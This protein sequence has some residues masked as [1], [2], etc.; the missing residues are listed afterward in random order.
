MNSGWRLSSSVLVMLAAGLLAVAPG[1]TR[2]AQLRDPLQP[3]G[4]WTERNFGDAPRPPMGWN[5]WNAFHT[6]IDEAKLLGS[7]RVIV[8]SGLRDLGY[9]YINIDDGWWL[10]RHQPDGRMVVRAG[11]FPSAFNRDPDRTSFRPLVDQLHAMHLKAGIYTDIGRN[12]CSQGYPQPDSLLPIGTIAEREVGLYGHVHQDLALYFDEWGFDYIKVDGCGLNAFAPD[13]PAVEAGQFRAFP[14]YVVPDSINQTRVA[15]IR[16]L[17]TEVRDELIRLRPAGNFVF[18]IC[19]WGTANV[20]AWGRD[21][22]NLWRTSDDIDGHWARMLYN[23]DSVATRE[24]YSGP[25]HWNDPDMLEVGHGDFDAHH[26]A[27]ARTHFALWAIE[28]APLIIGLDLRQAPQS[29]LDV[30][31]APEVI[32]VDQDPA[33]NQGVIAYDSDDLEIIVKQLAKRDQKAVVIFNRGTEPV[34]ATLTA[35]QLKFAVDAPIAVRD[36]WRRR[37]L[38][39]FVG[40]TTFSLAPRASMMLRVTGRPELRDGVYLSEMPARIYV[41]ADGIRALQADPQ[42]HRPVYMGDGTT[43]GAGPRPAL[44]GWGGPRADSTPY[45]NVLRLRGETFRSGIGALANSRLE[46]RAL[47]E[48]ARFTAR[49][50]VDDSSLERA[51]RVRF[52]VY[53]DGRLLAQSPKLAFTD[54]PYALAADV[55]GVDTIELIA[56]EFGDAHAP[57]LVTW[58]A[59][60]LTQAVSRAA[61]TP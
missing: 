32:A 11:I 61:E 58:G 27:A 18:S 37:D 26:L 55:K 4:H 8:E 6:R 51:T 12:S 59:A 45:D 2:A 48:F 24:L 9:R 56:R 25:G 43:R 41:A 50:G 3:A 23:F 16:A 10:S 34:K 21:V 1:G 42:I 13:R 19:N 35:A 28:D 20:R 33:G 57:T 17:Y 46:V 60:A 36:L 54:P 15:K 49:V 52:E 5:S 7:A 22:G 39:P 53:G 14:A 30:L 40:E 31:G 44:A 29:L 47:G 38:G